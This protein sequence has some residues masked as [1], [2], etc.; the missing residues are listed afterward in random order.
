MPPTQRE[1]ERNN[2]MKTNLK[3]QAVI[4]LAAALLSTSTYAIEERENIFFLGTGP[5]EKGNSLKNS[6]TPY[7]VGYIR[8]TK[9]SETVW[10]FDISGEGTMLDSTWGQ[11]RALSQGTSYN[12]LYGRNL[13]KEA[14]F[15]IDALILAGLR[16]KV[17][18]CPSSYLGYQCYA[19]TKPDTS[20]AGNIGAIL[21]VSYQ[22]ITVGFRLTSESRQ[23]LVGLRF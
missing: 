17:A 23:A 20:Y 2:L 19:N 11:N 14:T 18:S 12:F 9:A 6:D 13:S 22:R 4:A 15:R 10:G 5:A 1:R 8:T 16:E 7:S 21:A 3:I